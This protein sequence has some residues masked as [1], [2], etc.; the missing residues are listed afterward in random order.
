M[1]S[2]KNLLI[3]LGGVLY[4]IDIDATLE[5]YHA[6]QAPGAPRISFSKSEQHEAFSLLDCGQIDMDTF[7]QTLKNEYQ[8][9]GSLEEIKQVWMD[10]LVGV[11]EG[12]E[13]QINQLA[14]H[15]RLALLSN[16]SRF[17]YAHYAPQCAGMFEQMDHVF[18]SFDLGIRKPDAIIYETA[19][20]K[21]GWKAAETC[22]LDD[23]HTNIEAAGRVGLET[24]WVEQPTDFTRFINQ[25]LPTSA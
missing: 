2:V 18:T 3:D 17:H 21:A 20:E 24:F 25:V 5:R 19:L 15:Y 14:Q 11:F 12:R 23:S 22:F 4:E 1:Q 8:L 7:A 16:T 6:M 13:A 10:L 9:T